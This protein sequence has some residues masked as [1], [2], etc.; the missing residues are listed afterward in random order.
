[1]GSSAHPGPLEQAL[2]LIRRLEEKNARLETAS[3]VPVA[4][5]GLA[6][7]FPGAPDWPSFRELLRRGGH[8][9]SAPPADRL[10]LL[11]RDDPAMAGVT[12]LR[13]GYLEQVDQFDPE[14][15]G[16]AP[17]EAIEMDPQQRLA[18]EVSWEA[19]TNAG[20][21]PAVLRRSR[22][23]V[24]L[25][26]GQTDYGRYALDARRAE[27]MSAY[28]GTGTQISAAAGR[29]A[30]WLGLEGPCLTVDTACSSSLTAIHLAVR[31][32]RAGECDV[33][34]CGGVQL[35]LFPETF[36][37]LS[38]ALA[39]APDGVCKT[40]DAAADG[41]GR[42]EGC[43]MLVL[44]RLDDARRAGSSV[45]AVVRGS[46]I[47]HDGRSSG[48]TV[49]NGLAQRALLQSA[50]DDARVRP[51]EVQFVEAHGTGTVLGDPIEAEAIA[52]VYANGRA[53]ES[54]LFVGSVKA[55]VGHLE[56]AAGVA[57]AIK[58]ILAMEGGFVPAQPHFERPNPHIPWDRFPIQVAR[59]TIAWP[60]RGALRR[61]AVSAF[62]MSGS[63]AHLLLEQAPEAG[64]ARWKPVVYRRRSFWMAELDAWEET[65]QSPLLDGVLVKVR[66][67]GER[68]RLL[69]DHRVHGKVVVPGAYYL[70]MAASAHRKAHGGGCQFVDVVFPRVLT[71]EDEA[72]ELHLLLTTSSF[73]VASVRGP[74]VV[75]HAEGRVI[76][77]EQAISPVD[78]QCGELRDADEFYRNL[79]AR[80]IGLGPQFRWFDGVCAGA[81]EA[82]GHIDPPV[83]SQLDDPPGLVDSCFQLISALLEDRDVTYVPFGV[84][85]CWFSG[86]PL[87]RA[88]WCRA[89]RHAVPGDP[90]AEVDLFDQEGAA[91]LTMRGV[92]LRKAGETKLPAAGG[93]KLAYRIEWQPVAWGEIPDDQADWILFVDESELTRA[94]EATGRIG[95]VVRA[96]DRYE[97]LLQRHWRGVLFVRDAKANSGAPDEASLLALTEL[98]RRLRGTQ[99]VVAARGV[100]EAGLS[101]LART[102]AMERPELRVISVEL[103][104]SHVAN[105]ATLLLA[106]AQRKHWPAWYRIRDGR[107]EAAR[108]V[109]WDRGRSETLDVRPDATYLITGGTGAVGAHLARWLALRGA[110]NL[111][112]AGRNK[113]ELPELPSTCRVRWEPLDVSTPDQVQRLIAGLA[114]TDPPLRGIVHAAGVR[115][116]QPA[117]GVS[118][119][120]LADA[121][122]AK[123]KGAWNLHEATLDLPLDFAV[124][125]SSAAGLL[126][127][128][129]QAAYAAANAFVDAVVRQRR[130]LGLPGMSIAWGPWEETG[131]AGSLTGLQKDTWERRGIK[132]VDPTTA[133]RDLGEL[134]AAG[135]EYVLYL[136]VDWQRF[137][138]VWGSA[139]VP[140]LMQGLVERQRDVA[141]VM[142]AR[143][144][145]PLKLRRL[146]NDRV[147]AV[148]GLDQP[149]RP[150]SAFFDLGM[151]SLMAL[152]LRNDLQS[153]LGTTLP[154]TVVFD[155]PNAE[156][157]TDFLYEQLTPVDEIERMLLEKVDR[158]ERGVAQ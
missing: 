32:L 54:P 57:G 77:G 93:L 24:F 53:A 50:L 59:E 40:F 2:A 152:E 153:R 92:Q 124:W 97:H 21:Q 112:L 82:W 90:R 29:I 74:E 95:A 101:G 81:K 1:L 136:D 135:E 150:S 132:P 71:L 7:R 126:G 75:T 105:E 9:V 35:N 23:G 122:A 140:E 73:R 91:L 109:R 49:P 107:C 51:H 94:L 99:L 56:A 70:A 141:P 45:R 108:L 115:R 83:N 125:V 139:E 58:T 11:R 39:L 116:D 60:D 147:R 104:D 37:Y 76:G 121:M 131:M 118:P 154:A 78:I 158:L 63:N 42:G 14:F 6:C 113:R 146:V 148:L 66:L 87:R 143:D 34:L 144:I 110:R 55:N 10:R 62:G 26:M 142:D 114:K 157:L 41:Y 127:S 103:E 111:V 19:L 119:E 120:E 13:G 64:V 36:L 17:R 123:A 68:R 134:L 43:G 88:A 72:V 31:A 117:S 44:Q 137:S 133:L 149:L 15:F 100:A 67:D 130:R 102:L 98:A 138:K 106:A 85:E 61:A 156:A 65:V 18:L 69:A 22:T 3:Y 8:A 96:G 48:F 47:N 20:Y 86:E 46:A 5:T 151:D 27:A 79:E 84:E 25:G 155:Y 30:Y 129:G 80:Q 38:K 28:A 145:S 52:E 4:V 89:V 12:T 33:A 16:I 128:P